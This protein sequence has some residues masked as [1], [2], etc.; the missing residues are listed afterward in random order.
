MTGTVLQDA[1]DAMQ[2]LTGD[3]FFVT[4]SEDAS[5]QGRMQLMDS[6]WIVCSQTP[7]AGEEFSEDTIITFFAV[8]IG[9]TC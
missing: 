7:A 8:K 6:N 2:A 5:G 4:L 9:E 3:P 1:Q